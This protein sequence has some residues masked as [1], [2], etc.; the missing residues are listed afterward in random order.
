MLFGI[1]KD[2]LLS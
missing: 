1:F 2:V